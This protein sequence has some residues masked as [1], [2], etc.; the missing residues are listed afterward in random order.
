[1]WLNSLPDTPCASHNIS[2]S[3]C[4]G[5]SC[6]TTTEITTETTAYGKS[7]NVYSIQFN[8]NRVDYI[9]VSWYLAPTSNVKPC[10]TGLLVSIY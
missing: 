5:D 9:A 1:M 4:E 3:K 2:N 8:S 7:E 10:C 6:L